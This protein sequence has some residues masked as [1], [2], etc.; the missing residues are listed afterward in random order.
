MKVTRTSTQG[1][2]R[3]PKKPVAHRSTADRRE[4]KPVPSMRTKAR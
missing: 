4:D 3:A 2:H 1:H